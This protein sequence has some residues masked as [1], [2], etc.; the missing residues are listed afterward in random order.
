MP[1]SHD[2]MEIAQP[3]TESLLKSS[4]IAI[5]PTGSVEQHE[6]HFTAVADRIA[7]D[8]RAVISAMPE[9]PD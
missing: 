6:V 3:Q 2:L 8:V 9:V 4:G 1:H 5:I 7:S